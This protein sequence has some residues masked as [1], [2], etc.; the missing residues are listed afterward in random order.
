[1]MLNSRAAAL[2]LACVLATIPASFFGQDSRALL[3]NVS[4]GMGADSLRTI[5]FSGMGSNAGIG[6]NTNP[7]SRWPLV[8]VKTYT[9][10]ID[11]TA[12]ASH[13]R[14]VRVQNN[15]DETQERYVSPPSSWDSQ[16]SFWLTPF[17]F[18]KGAS[19]NNASLRSE[20][21]Q[22]TK[23]NIVSFS[24]DNKYKVVGY[25]N[26]KNLVE[27]VQT[28]ID[29]DVLGDMLVETF[30]DLYKD[31]DGVKFPTSIIEK[32][33]GFP[34]LILSVNEVKPNTSVSIQPPTPSVTNAAQP[35]SVQVEKVAD[36][37]YYF[38]GG[39]HHS[40]AVEFADHV[41]VIEAPLSEERSLAVI[42][43]V[44]QAIPNKPIRYLIN[45]HHHFDHAGGLRTYVDE[46]ATIVTH[47]SNKAFYQQTL[48]APRTLNPD[49]LARS[50][51]K[52]NIETVADKKVLSD[53]A[54]TLELHWIKGSPH[55]DG[56]LMAFLP[57]EKI[58]IEVDVF[59]PQNAAGIN[60][61]PAAVAVNP[62]TVNTVENVE[63][64]KLDFETIL[65]LHGPVVATRADLYKAINKP[66]P[67]IVAIIAAAPAAPVDPGRRALETACTV[68]HSLE[69][70]QTKN[71]P[72]DDWVRI[73]DDMK[74][75]G[76]ILQGNDEALLLEYLVK[77]Y[78]P[79]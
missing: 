79:K 3:T 7:N 38:K 52:P 18:L 9:Q 60:A 21:V 29:N 46:G 65:P 68:C 25:I 36:G 37:V 69:R 10:E 53:A 58:L 48:A 47:E 1:M 6:Q 74:G 30:Y 39:T 17:G 67:D 61:T 12:N 35:V 23:Y 40:V 43:A 42:A 20:T 26:D 27:R 22:G 78:G 63:K 49:R 41:A 72:Q 77:N 14:L 28:W 8:R 64:L 31:F 75:K 66:V 70:I 44:K 62:S 51:K 11:F 15:A 33:G 19:A 4:K 34:V 13:V 50:Q 57:K 24:L 54:R 32:Q 73:V 16:S 5:Q 2:G 59:T 45:T 56:I 71:M 55:D 76:A